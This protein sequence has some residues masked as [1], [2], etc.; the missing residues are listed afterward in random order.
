MKDQHKELNKEGYSFICNVMNEGLVLYER[1]EKHLERS[2]EKL[3]AACVLFEN[4]M[5]NDALSES[6]ITFS[7][8]NYN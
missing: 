7:C 6:I 5:F 8:G 2:E 4:K 1:E 3:S